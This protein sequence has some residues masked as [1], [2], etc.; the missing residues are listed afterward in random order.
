MQTLPQPL[1]LSHFHSRRHGS[2]YLTIPVLVSER[3][4][5]ERCVHLNTQKI[6]PGARQVFEPSVRSVFTHLT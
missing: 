4:I 5:L 1:S 6:Y 2:A 3:A